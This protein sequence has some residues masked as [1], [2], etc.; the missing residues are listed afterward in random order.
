V[1]IDT[2]EVYLGTECYGKQA[3]EIT[4]RLLPNGTLVRLLQESATD[5]V[6]QYGRLL[7]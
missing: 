5:R 3:S 2:P 6:D 7:R 1:R 4:K